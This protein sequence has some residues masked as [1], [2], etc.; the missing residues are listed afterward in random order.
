MCIRDSLTTGQHYRAVCEVAYSINE[1][2]WLLFVFLRA[3]DVH[4]SFDETPILARSRTP[5]PPLSLSL[6]VCLSVSRIVVVYFYP[7]I[8][9]HLADGDISWSSY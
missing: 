3:A 8:K 9:Q 1:L 4:K 6:S 5:L 7:S 2:F